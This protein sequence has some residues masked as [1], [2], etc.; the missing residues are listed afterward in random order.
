MTTKQI[1]HTFLRAQIRAIC[2][3][4]ACSGTASLTLAATPATLERFQTPTRELDQFNEDV[5]KKEQER[6]LRQEGTRARQEASEAQETG[7]RSAPIKSNV[8]FVLQAIEHSASEVLTQKEIQDIAKP[9][10]GKRIT[11]TEAYGLVESLNALYRQKGCI[12]CQASLQP[13]RIRNGILFVTLTEGKTGSVT[14]SGNRTTSQSFILQAL[15]LEPGKVANYRDLSTDL[16]AFNLTHD[17]V[18]SV[19]MHAG[20]KPGTTDYAIAVEEPAFFSAALFAD[21]L[22][23][24]STGRPRIGGQLRWA[25]LLGRRDALTLLG[26]ASHGTRTMQGSYAIPLNARATTLT[27]SG[28]LGRV[29]VIDGE[30]AALDIQGRSSSQE[31]RLSHVLTV[32]SR[33]KWE[34]YARLA[35]SQA[36]T[37]LSTIRFFDNRSFSQA[38]GLDSSFWGESWNALVSQEFTNTNS[39]DR[40]TGE[41]SNYQRWLGT[42]IWQQQL[43]A[44]WISTWKASWQQK[45]AGD[46]LASADTFSLGTSTGVRGYPNDTLTAES[47]VLGTAELQWTHPATRVSVSAFFDAGR[48]WSSSDYERRTLASAGATVSVPLWKDA[49]LQA[50]AAFPLIRHPWAGADVPRARFDLSFHAYW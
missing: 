27:L 49:N 45:V 50:S 38:L 1:R 44:S 34:A 41:T 30:T 28:S 37:D 18:L 36:S 2:F 3:V 19:D 4:I 7:A 9:L 39:H 24:N 10:V 16:T 42:A 29:K 17:V 40:M 35:W 33:Q 14:V 8:T 31:L 21:T 26:L 5:R 48:L 25:S 13:Q 22:G 47:G 23:A 6:Q 12:V 46:A 32:S 15:P 20:E 11:L 43:S